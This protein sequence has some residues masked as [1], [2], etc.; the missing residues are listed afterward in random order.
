MMILYTK[1]YFSYM[2]YLR[3]EC[4]SAEETVRKSVVSCSFVAGSSRG[5]KVKKMRK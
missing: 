4:A 3:D 5:S 1:E 2:R